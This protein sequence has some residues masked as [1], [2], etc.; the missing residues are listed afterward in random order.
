MLRALFFLSVGFLLHAAVDFFAA[1]AGSWA[2]RPVEIALGATYALAVAVIV[3]RL[4]F[5][6]GGCGA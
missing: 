2:R 3:A 1:L 6:W 4:V 5:C